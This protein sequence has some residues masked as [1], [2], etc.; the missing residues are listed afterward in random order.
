MWGGDTDIE[1]AW[2]FKDGNEV[3]YSGI[4]FRESPNRI[5]EYRQSG[6]I[7]ERKGDVLIDMLS[8]FSIKLPTP[9][10]ALHTRSFQWDSFKITSFPKSAG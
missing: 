10:F 2:V 3:A 9:F 5:K 6:K 7:I 4:E 8:S 1:F